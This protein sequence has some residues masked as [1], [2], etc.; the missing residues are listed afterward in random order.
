MNREQIVAE[1]TAQINALKL[2]LK[3]EISKQ[4]RLELQSTATK[5]NTKIDETC[6]KI[7]EN[8]QLVAINQSSELANFNEK[9]LTTKIETKIMKNIA[10]KY[11]VKIGKV[12]EWNAYQQQDTDGLVTSYQ[13]AV[14]GNENKQKLLTGRGNNRHVISENV[15]LAFEYDNNDPY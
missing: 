1:I 8:N 7:T 4:I 15:S 12:L 5:L 14:L 2:E 13:K 6:A 11:D 10:N 3:Q 9:D